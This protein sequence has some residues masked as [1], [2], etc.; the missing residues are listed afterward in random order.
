M[1]TFNFKDVLSELGISLHDKKRNQVV[2]RLLRKWASD[3]NV[4]A[5][6]VLTEKTN[7]NSSVNAPHCICH[8]PFK[9]FDDACE[10]LKG[11]VDGE[12]PKQ[13]TL[14]F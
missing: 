12:D 13:Q 3:K 2:G 9:Y 4:N 7:A 11:R 6:H 5:V 14:E 1:N 8:Y 10:A